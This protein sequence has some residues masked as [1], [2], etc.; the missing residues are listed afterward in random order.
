MNEEVGNAAAVRRQ[1]ETDQDLT[2]L[3][4]G[5]ALVVEGLEWTGAMHPAVYVTIGL[6][7]IAVPLFLFL[8]VYRKPAGPREDTGLQR[9]IAT[10]WSELGYGDGIYGDAAMRRAHAEMAPGDL[11]EVSGEPADAGYRSH[12]SRL[13]GKWRREG[14]PGERRLL[15]RRLGGG[16]DGSDDG[17]DH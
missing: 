2:S 13:L 12:L 11:P 16:A 14:A 6:L 8:V 9:N 4:G 1:G 17:G 5:D 15:R 7:I 10:H 3:L